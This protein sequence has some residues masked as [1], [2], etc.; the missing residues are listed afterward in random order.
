MA[1][2]SFTSYNK[3]RAGAYFNFKSV[4]R[5]M[6]TVGDRGIA[7][8]PLELSWGA[9]GEL[10]EVFSDELLNG[11]S[12][13]KVGFTA[14]DSESKLLNLMLQNC[15]KVLVYRTNTG[16]VKATKTIGNLT[17]TAKYTGTFGNNIIISIVENGTLFDVSTFVDGSQKDKQT[18]AT[19]QELDNNDFVDFSGT[20]S[21]TAN[22]GQALTGGTNGTAVAKATYY[23]LYLA[24]L[25]TASFQTLGCP[26]L[27]DTDT[28]LKANVVT[29]IRGQ[30][31]DQGRYIQGVIANYPTA[32]FE[33]II[34]VKN[35]FIVNG[36]NVTKEEA[37]AVVAA[38]TAGSAVNES[39]TN[40]VVQGATVLIGKYTNAQIIDALN[41]G[42]F[43][44]TTNQR[45]EVKVEKDINS[46][47]TFTQDK[48]YEFSKNRVLRVLDQFGTD[49]QDIWEQ[50]YMGK[51]DNTDDGRAI[52]KGDIIAYSQELY[53]IGALQE[54]LTADTLEVIK[55][56]EVDVV[57]AGAWLLPAD[58]MERLYFTVNVVG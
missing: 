52:F 12:L 58:A 57:I 24:L 42:E 51:V 33:G 14:F 47:H 55:G 20:G 3:V 19:A 48:N 22:A 41:G 46:L 16:G 7:T 53:R 36:E 17:A 32:D 29:F 27:E 39:N 54:P 34:S 31:D 11:E 23:P 40:R 50:S 5:P 28:A 9:I 45:G 49:V 38:M 1:G 30:R 21:L 8:V 18:V 15:Y 37:A 4:P 44:F 43:L 2:G 25:E 56:N 6:I 26:D 13:K 10:I 35:G